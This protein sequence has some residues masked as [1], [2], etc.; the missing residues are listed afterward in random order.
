MPRALVTGSFGFAGRHLR[1]LL[2]EQGWQVTGLD[3]APRPA[4][5]GE[6]FLPADLRDARAVSAAVAEAD[7]EVVFHLAG[8][9][10]GASVTDTLETNVVGTLHLLSALAER[11]REVRFLLAGSSAQYGAVPPEENPIH[12]ET[13]FRPVAVYGW[14]K[15]AAESA[16][17]SHHGQGGVEVIVARPFNHVGPDEPPTRAC[18][19]FAQQL[20]RIE[21]G[22][23][24]V[25]RVGNLE[26][27]RDF[28]DVRDVVR[29]YLA[30]AERGQP[31]RAYNLCSGRGVRMSELLDHLLGL[32]S[33]PVTVEP[34]PSRM[35]AAD[36]PIQVGSHER[37]TT[38]LGW[39]P[40]VPLETSL[41]ELL[42]YW[43]RTLEPGNPR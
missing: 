39:E 6:A 40:R 31:G 15:V 41:G 26:S 9:M 30:L 42:D 33:R 14:S 38:E 28:C 24:P 29:G 36:V 35:Q 19:A 2:R 37:A 3:S 21:A 20:A 17:M 34:D 4:P 25:L 43:R 22:A 10:G 7:P 12:E 32:C 1:A 11:G 18:S 5:P 13:R 8:L 27:I 16:A 23:E